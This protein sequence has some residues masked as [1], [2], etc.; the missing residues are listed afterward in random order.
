MIDKH[1]TS[2]SMV[3]TELL[4]KMNK[5]PDNTALNMK[6]PVINNPTHTK[7]DNKN[8]KKTK[9]ADLMKGMMTSNSDKKIPDLIRCVPQ[10][11]D[12]I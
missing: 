9:Y 5:S 10:K 6:L 2:M 1:T 8:K 11:I 4:K 7:D 3:H 12:H